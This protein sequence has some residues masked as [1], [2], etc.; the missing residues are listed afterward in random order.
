MYPEQNIDDVYKLYILK[1]TATLLEDV[2]RSLQWGKASLIANFSVNLRWKSIRMELTKCKWQLP[3]RSCWY[4]WNIYWSNPN[5]Q[6]TVH[7][8]YGYP[9]P[10]RPVIKSQFLQDMSS[11]YTGVIGVIASMGWPASTVSWQE[12]GLEVGTSSFGGPQFEASYFLHQKLCPKQ[13]WDSMD[14]RHGMIIDISNH[15]AFMLMLKH[16]P[17]VIASFFVVYLSEWLCWTFSS[18]LRHG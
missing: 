6:Q 17:H 5:S 10:S 14:S 7:K 2:P 8:S 9:S 3:W 1:I 12:S 11:E 4:Q 13:R 15:E 18:L 16:I